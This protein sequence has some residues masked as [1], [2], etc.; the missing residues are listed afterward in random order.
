MSGNTHTNSLYCLEFVEHM[1]LMQIGK[2][3]LVFAKFC[4]EDLFVQILMLNVAF[5]N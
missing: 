1:L 4:T 2:K 5:R 3:V